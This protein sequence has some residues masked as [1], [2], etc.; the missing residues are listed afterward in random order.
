M[1]TV[2]PLPGLAVEVDVA[3]RLLDEAVD[4]A[5]AEPAADPRPLGG[6]EGLEGALEHLRRHA[7]AGVGDGEQ[8]VG[9]RPQTELECRIVRVD[10]RTRRLDD[11]PAALRHGVA[12]VDR[13][14]EQRVLHLPR[15]GQGQG[16]IGGEPGLDADHLA[17]AAAQELAQ[18]GGVRA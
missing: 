16:Q 5:E 8:D 11:E 3:A 17:E 6:E 10:L 18:A 7:V 14:V 15:V 12:G 9:A 4:H 2:V 1:R 13:E